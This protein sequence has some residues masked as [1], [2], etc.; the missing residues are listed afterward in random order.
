MQTGITGKLL[1]AWCASLSGFV[2]LQT[3]LGDGGYQHRPVF[4]LEAPPANTTGPGWLGPRDASLGSAGHCCSCSPLLA[5]QP[6]S[7]GRPT[8]AE[9]FILEPPGRKSPFPHHHIQKGP[10]E[11]ALPTKITPLTSSDSACAAHRPS[12]APQ[13]T[14]NTP[15]T[16]QALPLPKTIRKA[17]SHL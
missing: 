13:K 11:E 6:A 8:L 1:R 12:S 4:P 17:A 2:C 16:R 7:A 14:A 15:H 5:S 9:P 10:K 3:L